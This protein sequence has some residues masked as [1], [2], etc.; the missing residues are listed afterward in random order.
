MC[1][2]ENP[3]GI[4]DEWIL[5]EKYE[6]NVEGKLYPIKIHLDA[7]YDPEGRRLRM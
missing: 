3:D 4:D 6:I 7:P 5:S 2:L 1:Y